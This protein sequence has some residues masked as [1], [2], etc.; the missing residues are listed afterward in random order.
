MTKQNLIQAINECNNGQLSFNMGNN[1]S[2]LFDKNWYPLR[3]T[4]NR[5]RE[6]NHETE[7]TTD[8]ALLELC[9]T[10]D[11]IKIGEVYFINCFPVAINQTEILNEV[12]C[13]AD[14]LRQLSE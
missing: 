9:M 5:A 6:I 2:F 7:L 3:A 13:I 12:K 4:I 14:I 10:F 1:R 8:R 11:Y